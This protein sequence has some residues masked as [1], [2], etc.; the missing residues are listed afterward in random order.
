M[1]AIGWILTIGWCVGLIFGKDQLEKSLTTA[2]GTKAPNGPY[3][4]GDLIFSD[5]FNDLDLKMWQHEITA[6]GG[7][8][9]THIL[10]H[11]TCTYINYNLLQKFFYVLTLRTIVT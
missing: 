9:S 10:I 11:D 5:D 3:N 2:S 1:A 4:S 8:V 6:G 7:G